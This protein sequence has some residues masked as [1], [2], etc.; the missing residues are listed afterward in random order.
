MKPIT[1]PY[2]RRPM[3]VIPAPAPVVRVVVWSRKRRM[4]VYPYGVTV[5][6]PQPKMSNSGTFAIHDNGTGDG[7]HEWA[8]Y[9]PAV[10]D[11]LGYE[12]RQGREK[13][14][15]VVGVYR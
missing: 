6:N 13:R 11:V 5:D 15:E 3:C 8:H 4:V 1:P 2:D 9:A 7:W 12:I 14:Y 10:G